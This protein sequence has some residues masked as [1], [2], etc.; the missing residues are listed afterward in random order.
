MVRQG[1]AGGAAARYLLLG[2]VLFLTL[3]GLVM[4]F[5]AGFATDYQKFADS[6]YHV[7]RQAGWVALGMAGMLVLARVDYRG[8][9]R[10][11]WPFLGAADLMLLL[12]LTHGIGKSGAQRWISVLGVPIQ[13]SEFA[14][15]AV[16]LAVAALLSD[17]RKREAPFAHQVGWLALVVL[18]VVALIML[19]PDMGTAMIIL[20][21][22]FVLLAL[23]GISAR[24]L[25]GL[26]AA[27]A[28]AVPAMIFLEP[29]R[30]ARFLSFLDPWKDPQRDGY[31]IIQALYAFGSGGLTGVGLGLSRQKYFYLPAAHTDF[32]FAIIGEELGLVGTLAVIAGFVVLAYAGIR[33][34]MGARDRFGR[35]LAGSLTALVVAQAVMN[36]AAV[37]AVMPVTGIPLPLLSYGGSSIIFTLGCIGM[38]LSVSRYGLQAERRRAVGL[39]EEERVAN[40]AER[41]RDGRPHLSS[42]DGGRAPVRRRA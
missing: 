28:V 12:V 10:L 19:Q 40:S 30:A 36:I 20:V 8:V 21:S 6:A 16:V 7:K 15:L 29:Y 3:F 42:I 4:I 5:S 13:P 11:A 27:A 18:P 25:F 34:A 32:V 9:R 1:Y 14:K 26:A 22:T 24:Y 35:M 39:P 31:Q 33:I 37:T 17:R 2:A 38:V 23:G 41:R